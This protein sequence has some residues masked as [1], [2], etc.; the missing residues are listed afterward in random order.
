MARGAGT[1][2]SG[3]ARCSL[4]SPA[5]APSPGSRGCVAIRAASG[6]PSST[7]TQWG[8]GSG[9]SG[10]TRR[11]SAV[12]SATTPPATAATTSADAAAS[13]PKRI[14]AALERVNGFVTRI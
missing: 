7:R 1:H 3:S 8:C 5:H 14:A 13:L 6:F 11:S 10:G 2:A 12:L 9:S 4:A